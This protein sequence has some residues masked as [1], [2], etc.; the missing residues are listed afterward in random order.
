MISVITPVYNTGELVLSLAESLKKQGYDDF[1]W[2]VVDDGS[3]LKTKDILSKLSDEVSWMKLFV[4]SSNKGACYARNYGFGKSTGDWIK[5]VDGDDCISDNMLAEQMYSANLKSVDMIVSPAISFSGDIN[6]IREVK[7][8]KENDVDRISFV[9]GAKFHHSG[10]LYRR[11][12]ISCVGGWREDLKA[13]QDGDFL[14]RIL[15]TNPSVVINNSCAFYY[16]QHNLI[17]RITSGVNYDKLKSRLSVCSYIAEQEGRPFC[18]EM[19]KALANKM[20]QI[21]YLVLDDITLFSQ[22]YKT[23]YELLGDPKDYQGKLGQ[24]LVM[25][26]GY[27]RYLLCK[28]GIVSLLMKNDFKIF[29]K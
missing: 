24:F 15:R 25:L 29:K 2:I 12:L 8:V 6:S 11:S 19:E 27:R 13:D 7:P 28:R 3:D 9:A 23:Y 10:C 20:N 17:P 14:Y 18:S 4:L 5:F 26:V 1:E 16:R 21:L 22:A